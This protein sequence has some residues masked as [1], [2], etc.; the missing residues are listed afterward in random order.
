MKN[1][2]TTIVLVLIML[3]LIAGIVIFGIAIYSDLNGTDLTQVAYNIKKIDTEEPS[4]KE[5]KEGNTKTVNMQSLIGKVSN[6]S[7]NN[8]SQNN[9]NY[10]YNEELNN[11]FFYNQLNDTQK[12]LYNGLYNNKENLKQ[13][14]YI[15]NYGDA[16]SD[17]LS[18]ENGTD[19]LGADYQT[20]TEA[21]SHDNPDIFYIDLNK[22]YLN[23][24]TKTKL[25]KTTY[26]AYVGAANGDSYLLKDFKSTEEVELASNEIEGIANDVVASLKGNDYQNILYIHDYLVNNIEYDTTLKAIGSYN[27]YG[28]LITKKCV[29]EGYAKAFKY[30]ANRAGYECEI[31]Q[32]MATNSSGQ[33]ES[34]AWN[35]VKLNGIWYQIDTTWDDPIIIGNGKVSNKTKYNYFLKGTA[36]FEKD[37]QIKYNFSEGGK[38][39]SYPDMSI[40]DY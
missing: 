40:R 21:F 14:D 23:I 33:T 38:K 4:E 22:M 5:N 16:F 30:I 25:F 6:N 8:K 9:T 3:A 20:V 7:K 28:A 2:F 12:L 27:I 36:T 15:I 37:H 1:A 13:G 26:N 17:I 10:K 19:K 24:E 35:C 29:C 34:H 31:L 39:F 18:E 32:G 11:K